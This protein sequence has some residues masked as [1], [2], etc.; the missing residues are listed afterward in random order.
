[1]SLRSSGS[2]V[3][4]AL[5]LGACHAPVYETLGDPAT[6]STGTTD[7]PT[8]TTASP[9]SSSTGA[10]DVA[11]TADTTTSST[12]ATTTTSSTS[13]TADDTTTTATTTP[14]DPADCGNAEIDPGETCDDGYLNNSDANACT[15]ACQLNVC[16]DGLVHA[17]EEACDHGEDNNDT[18]YN[19]CTTACENGPTCNDGIRQ[20]PEECDAGPANG[21]SESP[22]NGV[23]CSTGCRFSAKVTFLSSQAYA[24]GEIGGVEGAHLKCQALALQ[25]GYDN[26][27]NFK[28]WIS[29]AQWSPALGFTKSDIPYV[30]P[31]GTRIADDWPD[32]IQNGPGNGIIRT[33]TGMTQLDT[34]SWTGTAP[35]GI[36]LDSTQTCKSWTSSLALDKS[37]VGR[38]G[39]DPDIPAEWMPWYDERQWSSAASLSC[40]YKNRLYCVEQ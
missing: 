33:E 12:T 15:L 16:G 27:T 25:A 1:M 14:A 31:D 35:S 10:P 18:L 6:T 36:V 34:W 32:L 38:T 8:P 3:L 23:P 37:R 19:G 30:L 2:L 5:S 22:P 9:T 39:V 4:T 20:D 40:E 29:D 7:A 21:T 28:A 13:T 26:A 17:G 11:T 24:G